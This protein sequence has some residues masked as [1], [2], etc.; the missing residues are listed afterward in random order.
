LL[1]FLLAFLASFVSS[2]LFRS[3]SFFSSFFHLLFLCLLVIFCLCLLFFSFRRS[4]HV[5]CLV[6]LQVSLPSARSLVQCRCQMQFILA[7]KKSL[8]RFLPSFLLLCTRHDPTFVH[9]FS[10]SLFAGPHLLPRKFLPSAKLSQSLVLDQRDFEE[11]VCLALDWLKT[12][13]G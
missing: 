4:S 3:F 6:R 7:T 1:S 5:S 10:E 13:R 11:K 12:K 8:I 9:P 2:F